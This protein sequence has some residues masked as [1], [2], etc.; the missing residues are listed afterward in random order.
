MHQHWVPESYLRAWCDP[1]SLHL[2]NP[3]VWRFSKDGSEVKSKSPKKLFRE[4]NMYTFVDEKGRSNQ[5]IEQGLSKLED[6]FE[7]LR[8]DEI[9]KCGLLTDEDK[10]TLCLF[11]AA[12]HF[13]TQRSRDHWKRQ[14]TKVVGLG[15]Q[16]KKHVESLSP[17][18]KAELR[19]ATLPPSG[20]SM[21][22]E[23]IRLL[24]EQPLRVSPPV[25]TREAE[26]LSDMT[27]TIL[28]ALDGPGFITSDA[29]VVWWDLELYKL[30]RFWRHVDLGSPTIEV[31]MPISPCRFLILTHH[32][33]ATE[34]YLPV[35]ANL[36]IGIKLIDDVNRRTRFHCHDHFVSNSNAKKGIWFDPGTPRVGWQDEWRKER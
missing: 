17:E 2:Q 26:L 20:P 35:P 21:S 4:S 5:S 34:G 13:R 14:W 31:T 27:I 10:A 1:A 15:D 32:G 18:Q 24:A 36:E 6:Q 8:R 19:D 11:V 33:R 28:C 23:G 29:P 3:Y 25:T 9:M 30:P 7:R 16:I 12:A 22:L